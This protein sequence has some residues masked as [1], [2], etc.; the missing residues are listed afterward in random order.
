MNK[1][2]YLILLILAAITMIGCKS[3]KVDVEEEETDYNYPV[4]IISDTIVTSISDTSTIYPISTELKES[5]LDKA[6]DYLGHKV[7]AKIHF[8][9]EWG[10]VCLERLPNGRELM[11]M[12]SKNREWK[13]LVV[14]SGY[15]TQR[16]LDLMPIAVNVAVQNN[17]VLET[18]K[19]KSY[20][21]PDGSFLIQKTYE[22]TRSVT[23]ATKQQVL[24]NPENYHRKSSFT[25]QYFINDNGRF[26]ASAEIDTIPDYNA[27]VFFYNRNEKPEIW[28]EHVEQLQS[29]CE[30][31]EIM[32]EEVYQN[33]NQILIQ[34]FDLSFSITAD[35]TPYINGIMCGMVMLKKGAEPKAINFGSVEYMQ[36][37]IKRYFKL[38]QRNNNIVI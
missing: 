20:R 37:E 15:G 10:V 2:T 23:K 12:Q 17:D 18:E 27:V 19:W 3:K 5:F 8:P 1:K 4:S 35:I 25:E 16:I 28:D 14:T 7:A 33:Y 31:N 11:L 9:E 29:Y 38:N 22:W 30:E 13:Y 24:A 21:K 32:F 6:G 36:M 26:E 34:N